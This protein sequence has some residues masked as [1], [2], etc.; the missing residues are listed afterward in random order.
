M[1]W[2]IVGLDNKEL[3]QEVPKIIPVFD[4]MILE[5]YDETEPNPEIRK[6]TGWI[7]LSFNRL[8]ENRKQILR[9]Y[10]KKGKIVYEPWDLT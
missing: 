2:E 8:G 5:M 4:Q 7:H 10:R 6:E 9:A 3:A 1:D